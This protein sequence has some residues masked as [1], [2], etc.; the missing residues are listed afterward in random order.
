MMQARCDDAHELEFVGI[1][2]NRV[3]VFHIFPKY[4]LRIIVQTNFIHSMWQVGKL[5]C[6]KIR[7]DLIN[8][9]I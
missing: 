3:F 7:L 9:I 6:T 4:C 5:K 8:E 2:A 1:G